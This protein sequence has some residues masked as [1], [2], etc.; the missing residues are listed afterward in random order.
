MF[1]FAAI[2]QMI[3]LPSTVICCFYV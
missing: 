1:S 2:E 3:F